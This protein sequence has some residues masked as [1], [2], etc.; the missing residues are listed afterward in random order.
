MSEHSVPGDMAPSAS[1]KTSAGDRG[2]AAP[3]PAGASPASL[4]TGDAPDRA[5]LERVRARDPEALEAF[6]ER[7][8]DR[9]YG[10]V[11]R[12]LGDRTLA[13]DMTQ[14]V[15]LKVHRA[16]HQ[17]D[18]GRDPA[19]WIMTIAHNACRDLWRSNAWKL[20]RRAASLDGDSPLAATLTR[21]TNDPERDLL[22]DER[23]RLVQDALLK[24]PEPLRVAIVMHDYQGLGH[25]EIAAATGVQHAAARKRYSRALAALAALLKDTL[26]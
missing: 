3:P 21:G 9:V 26:G 17:L 24:L 19:P 23:E 8:F 13:E 1:S 12:L 4:R 7:Y 5:E 18:P 2:V 15:F 11:Y 22:A 25:E 14:E 16:A 10:L 6:F 20:T